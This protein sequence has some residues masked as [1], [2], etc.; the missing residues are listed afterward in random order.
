MAKLPAER[1]MGLEPELE[2]RV[3]GA[4]ARERE[5]TLQIAIQVALD[6]ASHSVSDERLG[7][8][9]TNRELFPLL[10]RCGILS[11]GLVGVLGTPPASET[12]SC[13]DTTTSTLALFTTSSSTGWT[14][15]SLAAEIRRWMTA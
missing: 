5:H 6:V 9:R 3:A 2:Q 11:M 1:M 7:E 8:P 10:G 15:C 14:T 4:R 13:T 12:C